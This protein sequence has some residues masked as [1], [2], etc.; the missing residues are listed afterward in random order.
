MMFEVSE[1]EARRMIFQN[2]AVIAAGV[3]SNPAQAGAVSGDSAGVKHV[4][5]VS[6]A[7]AQD[8]FSACG[9]T[10]AS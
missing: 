10:V 3:L 5:Q 1:P 6:V 8:M 9:F 2:A 4:V 7:V